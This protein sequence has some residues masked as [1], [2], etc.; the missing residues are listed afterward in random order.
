[1]LS[2]ARLLL[3]AARLLEPLNARNAGSVR[4]LVTW[5]GMPP[6]FL[7]DAPDGF[8]CLLCWSIGRS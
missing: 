3:S 4:W 5:P 7:A 2:A 8:G 1:M 6:G